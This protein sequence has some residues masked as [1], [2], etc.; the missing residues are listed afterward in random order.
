M[1]FFTLVKIVS[2]FQM[3]LSLIF[4]TQGHRFVI[5]SF[6]ALL[7]Y[8]SGMWSVQEKKNVKVFDPVKK[9]SPEI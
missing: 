7:Y 1:T 3:H 9:I 8:F 5:F 2:L 4:D 6:Y